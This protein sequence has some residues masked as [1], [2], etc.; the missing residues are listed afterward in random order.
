M[1]TTG[2]VH[3]EEFVE[4]MGHKTQVRKGGAG[5]SLLV[6][7][8]ELGIPGWTEAL[9]RLAETSRVYVP[10]LPGFG[11]SECPEW[12][13]SM[14]DMVNWVV[15]FVADAER[16]ETRLGVIGL[17]MGGWIA[18]L[19]AAVNRNLFDKL[20]LVNPCGVKPKEGE[21]WDY[22]FH[23]AKEGLNRAVVDPSA[24]QFEKYY[25]GEWSLEQSEQAEV[26]RDM[27]CRLLWKPYMWSYSTRARVRGITT[28]TLILVG[29]QDKI[30]PNNCGE[31]L[32]DT[33]AGSQY[34]VI[35]N[36]G[37][38]V[39]IERPAEF[40]DLTLKFLQPS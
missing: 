15:S 23:S 22:F 38:L 18:A 11:G 40:V 33:I 27:A 20:V 5:E 19:L 10:S 28:P 17:S 34:E 16:I 13:M 2:M 29:D 3:T 26:N 36:S 9:D 4:V 39:D 31:I 21:I 35:K 6:L 37:H 8:G 24:P 32:H 30:V 25:G 14:D 1:V 12:L 7:H